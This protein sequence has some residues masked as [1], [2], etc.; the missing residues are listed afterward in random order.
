M[1]KVLC[2]NE[3]DRMPDWAFRIMAMMFNIGDLIKSP[4]SRLEPFNIK[5]G[6]TIVDW[7][8]GTGRYLRSASRRVG[9][10]GIVY[11]VDIH[12]LAVES[13][14]QIMRKNN[15]KNVTPLLTDGKTVNIPLHTVDL[16]YA[17][18]MFH[19]VSDPQAFLQLL[20]SITRPGGSLILE[21]GHQ[22]RKLTKEKVLSSG[23]WE[24]I[25]ENKTYITCK[26]INK[27]T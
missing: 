25:A 15:L 16:I 24:V 7:G 20:F 18:D 19:M 17:L 6:Q 26:P 12:P 23:C 4:D 3:M 9:G 14:R 11:G 27:T 22:P 2:G 21:D 5:E 13:A 10:K 1:K 8:C